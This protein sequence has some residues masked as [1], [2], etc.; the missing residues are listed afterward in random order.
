MTWGEV[1]RKIKQAG[2]KFKA[3]DK[4]HDVYYN[5]KTGAEAEIPRH[6]TKE[7]KTGTVKAIF[8]KLGIK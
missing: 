1:L 3:N 6:W 7:A 5:P 2:C 8:K 4:R